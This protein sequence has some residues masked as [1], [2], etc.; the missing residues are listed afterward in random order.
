MNYHLERILN[1]WAGRQF[2]ERLKNAGIPFEIK[3]KD[4]SWLR[5][6]NTKMKDGGFITITTDITEIKQH[7]KELEEQKELYS[8]LIDSINGVVFDWDLE[9]QKVDYSIN[10]NHESIASQFLNFSNEQEVFEILDP[11]DHQRFRETLIQHFKKENELFEF[12]TRILN[13][14]RDLEWNR[15][16]GKA[17]WNDEGR[18]VRMIGLIENIDREMKLRDRLIS[19][20][21][22]LADA[23]ENIPVGLLIWNQ[24]EDRL[25]S[26]N[27]I[28]KDNFQKYGV[29]IYP[30]VEFLE[31]MKKVHRKQWICFRSQELNKEDVLNQLIKKDQ[32]HQSR[33][34]TC[35]TQSWR[36]LPNC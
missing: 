17:R 25:I 30:G 11:Q 24:K 34:Q 26:F 28:M 33:Y 14:N 5:H 8:F 13:E 18:A 12:E 20:E 9:T 15:I 36:S 2:D 10:P 4:G 6:L 32:M 1:E 22:T 31:T 29:D 35:Q 21:K 19:A 3:W 16:R 7:E 23:M 27:K